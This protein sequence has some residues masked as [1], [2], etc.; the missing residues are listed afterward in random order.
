M[1]IISALVSA[2]QGNYQAYEQILEHI[3]SNPLLISSL[4]QY[5]ANRE[6]PHG[7]RELIAIFIKNLLQT[8][9]F[10][11]WWEGTSEKSAII[12]M[13][14]EL[15]DLYKLSSLILTSILSLESGRGENQ[16]LSLLLNYRNKCTLL[17]LGYFVENSR[18]VP[19]AITNYI[20]SVL[21]EVIREDLMLGLKVFKLSAKHLPA[22][23]QLFSTIINV[24]KNVKGLEKI[25]AVECLIEIF[26]HFYDSL[27]S[28]FAEITQIIVDEVLGDDS[29]ISTLALE[30]W[31]I[32]IDI[33]KQRTDEGF[34]H[35][36]YV[37]S[38]TETIIGTL[39]K[40][41]IN[42][43]NSEDILAFCH[44]IEGVSGIIQDN[45]MK[46]LPH[47]GQEILSPDPPRKM[48]ALYVLGSILSAVSQSNL[49][50]IFAQLAQTI[51]DLSQSGSDLVTE[52][53]VWVLFKFTEVWPDIGVQ[54]PMIVDILVAL[55]SSKSAKIAIN[56]LIEILDTGFRLKN[57]KEV[58][59]VLLGLASGKKLLNGFSAVRTIVEYLP[60]DDPVVTFYTSYLLSELATSSHTGP[61]SNI[62]RMCFERL[63]PINLGPVLPQTF[64]L[65]VNLPF[66]ED[67]LIATACISRHDLF[68]PYLQMYTSLLQV[69][70]STPEH[71][72]HGVLCLGELLRN[73][74]TSYSSDLLPCVS[75]FFSTFSQTSPPCLHTFETLSDLSSLHTSLI[76]PSIN[77]ILGYTDYSMQCSLSK[78]DSDDLEFLQEL[79]ESIVVFFEGFV[80]GLSLAGELEKI[81]GSVQ[82]IVKYCLEVSKENN[83]PSDRLIGCALGVFVDIILTWNQIL[84]ADEVKAFAY[85][86]KSSGNEN[87]RVNAECVIENL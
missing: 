68:I 82:G 41:I 40:K 51:T 11:M 85:R 65:L 29:E 10:S 57:C 18:T 32:M 9:A 76:L 79:Q 84:Y 25:E 30:C 36:N 24:C 52:A 78:K 56:A 87:I 1:D 19:I 14:I 81:I 16:V 31:N 69:A 66:S 5:I 12:T 3:K 17:S 2:Q 33:E 26:S 59:E 50:L 63:S 21:G 71:I 86:F 22:N 75:K 39:M 15:D 60:M 73:L 72:K 48:C 45:S 67:F 6:N 23:P 4:F 34:Q 77:E 47:L 44:T 54:H 37:L 64:T 38:L 46:L 13:L 74:D 42:S 83:S 49:Q 20:T 53:M 7:S 28:D 61:I 62:L 58:T 8:P 27:Q 80:Q 55:L 43:D 70:L 35:N